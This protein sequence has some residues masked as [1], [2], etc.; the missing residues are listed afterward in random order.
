MCCLECFILLSLLFPLL[1]LAV[2]LDTGLVPADQSSVYSLPVAWRSN[3]KGNGTAHINLYL[4]LCFLLL[5]FSNYFFCNITS[6]TTL[7]RCT[8]RL[9]TVPELADATNA[10]ANFIQPR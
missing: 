1:L 6:F 7:C 4:E 3:K 8:E 5:L 2:A 9:H 10:H